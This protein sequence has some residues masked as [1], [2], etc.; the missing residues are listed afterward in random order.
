MMNSKSTTINKGEK[1]MKKTNEEIIQMITE[2]LPLRDPSVNK[3]AFHKLLKNRMKAYEDNENIDTLLDSIRK[4]K[5][6]HAR[7]V[8]LYV[9]A[10]MIL[11][12]EW[13]AFVDIGEFIDDNFKDVVKSLHRGS[14]EGE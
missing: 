1:K 12:G 6:K 13:R 9:I 5:K 4:K 14:N 11:H 10:G 8:L 2:E 3:D 7:F